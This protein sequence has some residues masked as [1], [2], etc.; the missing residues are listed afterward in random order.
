MGA[1]CVRV[2]ASAGGKPDASRSVP[3]DSV[4]DARILEVCRP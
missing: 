1:R 4:E 2:G 3:F